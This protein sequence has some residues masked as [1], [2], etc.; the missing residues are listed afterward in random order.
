MHMATSKAYR[1]SCT[2]PFRLDSVKTTYLD[3][4]KPSGK[5]MLKEIIKAAI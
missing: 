5:L 2:R 1:N 3:S 4:A